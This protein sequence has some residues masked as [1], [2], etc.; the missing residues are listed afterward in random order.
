MH[1]P[2][3]TRHII[4]PKESLLSALPTFPR[5]ETHD[6]SG[7]LQHFLTHPTH[8][9]GALLHRLAEFAGHFGPRLGLPMLGIGLVVIVCRGHGAPEPPTADAGRRAAG[10]D[11]GSS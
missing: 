4:D 6:P 5:A 11:P 9:T 10:S 8:L 1:L 3:V 7:P 2:A